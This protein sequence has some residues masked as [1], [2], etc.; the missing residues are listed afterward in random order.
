MRIKKTFQGSIPEN[1]IVNAQSNS[2]TDTYSCDY[3]NGIVES[4]ENENGRWTKWSDGTMICEMQKSVSDLKTSST[5]G[6]GLY[7]GYAFDNEPINFP[8]AFIEKP[9]IHIDAD[10]NETTQFAM[11]GGCSY[12]T[13]TY[14]QRISLV[15]GTEATISPI[16][17]ITAIGKWK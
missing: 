11:I 4:G 2:Q 1:K 16:L 9:T 5:W 7:Y 13:E 17:H 12:V 8:E 14:I 6:T 15:R 3:I 10:L